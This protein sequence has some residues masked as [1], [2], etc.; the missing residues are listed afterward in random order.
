MAAY[1]CFVWLVDLAS[2]SAKQRF[3]FLPTTNIYPKHI[4]I[5]LYSMSLLAYIE[6]NLRFDAWCE[7]SSV[8]IVFSRSVYTSGIVYLV[9]SATIPVQEHLLLYAFYR[10]LLCCENMPC[11]S[12]YVGSCWIFP[13][14]PSIL[15]WLNTIFWPWKRVNHF[16]ISHLNSH[17]YS[18]AL[19][20]NSFPLISSLGR[21]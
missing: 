2:S 13:H 3:Q 1:G 6:K 17:T 11:F 12:V 5:D 16:W 20:A 10:C 7:F 18:A 15:C 9:D 4:N 14:I 8:R 21:K 19:A